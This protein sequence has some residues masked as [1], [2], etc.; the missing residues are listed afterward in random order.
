MDSSQGRW[1]SY[2]YDYTSHH[3]ATTTDYRITPDYYYTQYGRGPSSKNASKQRE[4][5]NSYHRS[6]NRRTCA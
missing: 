1:G 6:L 2:D 4:N 5:G 3:L